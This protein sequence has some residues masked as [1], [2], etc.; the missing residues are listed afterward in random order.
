MKVFKANMPCDSKMNN[1]EE[2]HHH[3]RIIANPGFYK[4]TYWGSHRGY[5]SAAVL[6]ARSLFMADM[7]STRVKQKKECEYLSSYRLNFGLDHIEY[8]TG[9]DNKKYQVCSQQP[10]CLTLTSQ[11]MENEGWK[12]ILPMYDLGQDTY[13]RIYD[14]EREE[15]RKKIRDLLPKLATYRRLYHSSATQL[16]VN[17]WTRGYWG[18]AMKRK[19]IKMESKLNEFERELGYAYSEIALAHLVNDRIRE[20]YGLTVTFSNPYQPCNTS[21]P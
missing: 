18:H 13:V 5:P 9:K 8:Y 6:S 16:P 11:Q 7:R 20:E 17:E 12:K 19:L 15:I 21:S 1:P 3:E 14:R 10:G 2:F 4:D